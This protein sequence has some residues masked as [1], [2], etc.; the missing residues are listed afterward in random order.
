[1]AKFHTSIRT[2]PVYNFYE[3]LN[4]GE[5]SW[6]YIDEKGDEDLSEVWTVIYNEYCEAAK[7][8]NRH[9]KQI[10]KVAELTKKYNKIVVLM[11]LLQDEFYEVREAA[12]KALKG[13]NYIFRID[14]PFDEEYNRLRVQLKSLRT[15]VSIEES[16]LPKEQKKESISIM[17]QAVSLENM[18]P[19]RDIDIYV[20]PVQ[21]WLALIEIAKEKVNA[22]KQARKR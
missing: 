21:K 4:T 3:V 5:Y 18:F 20:M 14:R 2:L 1:M 11:E 8:D 19:G 10:A 6:L 13:Y 9:M 17:K 12:R 16:K 15:K 22:Q 7:I